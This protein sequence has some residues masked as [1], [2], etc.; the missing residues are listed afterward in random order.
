MTERPTLD[1]LH[2]PQRTVSKPPSHDIAESPVK[3]DGVPVSIARHFGI[4]VGT[5]EEGTRR[6]LKDIYE[7]SMESVSP[8]SIGNS[9]QYLRDIR[10]KLGDTGST[11]QF[12]K[13]W[14]W[15]SINR[16]INDLLKQRNSMETSNKRYRKVGN[17]NIRTKKRH[18]E[19]SR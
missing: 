6:Y 5:M 7:W 1:E 2:R 8:K 11:P 17:V 9:L 16:K 10:L 14:N 13:I 19:P 18:P 15:L 12:L 4:D 3:I